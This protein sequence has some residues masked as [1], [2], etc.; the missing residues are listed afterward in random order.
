M[1]PDKTTAASL[2]RNFL[3]FL[4]PLVLLGGVI[5]LFLATGGAGLRIEP[6]APVETLIFE[7]TI[8]RPGEI[9]LQV[10]NT[11]PQEIEIA[12]VK[13]EDGFVTFSILPGRT[14]PRLGEARVLIPYP[15]VEAEAYVVTLFSSSSVPFE[16]AIDVATETRTAQAQTLWSFTLIGLYVGVIPVFLGIFWL[17]ALRRL[18]QASFVWLMAVT[19]GLLIY[20]GIDAASEALETAAG[21]GGA[22]QG[23]GLVGLGIVGTFLLLEAVARRQTAKSGEQGRNLTVSLMI[24]IGIGLHNL[25][26]GLAIGAAFSIGAAS[27]GTFLVV[28]FILQNITEGLGIIAPIVRQKPSAAA[29]LG[30]GL[31]GGVPAIIGTWMGG[32]SSSTALSALFL[33]I[34]SG[35]VFQVASQIAQL[36]KAQEASQARP[37]TVFSGV[38]VGMVT[39]YLTGFLIK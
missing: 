31:I 38:M 19:V 3:F 28:G 30:L 17:P 13:V 9:E 15:W 10:R 8:L 4:V 36:I 6:A 11:S 39:L 25:G 24:S 18:G 34:G 22:F 16:T 7:R 26:E 14:V 32:L 29:L 1:T 20:L 12:Q 23:P 2:A 35:A 33:A 5:A 37:M 21:L 27:L